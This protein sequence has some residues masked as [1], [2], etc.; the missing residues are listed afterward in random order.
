MWLFKS[1]YLVFGFDSFRKRRTRASGSN[2]KY[3]TNDFETACVS[4]GIGLGWT[5]LLFHTL[6]TIGYTGSPH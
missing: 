4:L 6:R 1:V 3:D 2:E 5:V